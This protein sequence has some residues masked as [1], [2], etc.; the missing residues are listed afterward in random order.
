M[1][2]KQGLTISPYIS[3]TI[4]ASRVIFAYSRDDALP[5]SRWLKMVNKHTKSPVNAVWFCQTIGSLLGLLMFASPVA[6]GAVFSL[7]AI[8]QYIAFIT[9]IALKLFVVGNKFRPGKSPD[10]FKVHISILH[11]VT[12]RIK[13]LGIS[14]ASLHL[15]EQWHVLSCCS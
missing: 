9:P 15:S 10:E 11:T 4:S 8:A 6:I 5:F 1:R 2:N 13:D 12:E 7:G 3:I 14:V